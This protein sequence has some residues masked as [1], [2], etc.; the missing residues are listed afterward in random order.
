[1]SVEQATAKVEPILNIVGDKVALGPLRRDLLP[2]YQRWIN[3]FSTLR[4]LAQLPRPM[5]MEQEESWYDSASAGKDDQFNFTIY[6]RATLRAIGNT[7]L[8]EVDFRNRTCSFG[9][10]IGEEAARGQGC[11]TEATRLMLDFAFTALGLHNVMLTVY[12]FNEAGKRAYQKAGF[13]EFGRRREA[14]FMG[15][16]YWDELYMQ[17]LSTEFTSPA[18]GKILVPDVPRTGHGT[19]TH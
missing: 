10:L 7:A 11:G 3:D 5:T 18:L 19:H 2:L 17:A 6:E 13:R 12:D 15:G 14:R 9:I 16:T 4:T 8:A 1:M